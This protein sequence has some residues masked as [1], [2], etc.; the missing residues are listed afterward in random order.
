VTSEHGLSR[1]RVTAA[2]RVGEGWPVVPEAGVPEVGEAG[3]PV[4][5]VIGLVGAVVACA[6]RPAAALAVAARVGLPGAGPGVEQAPASSAARRAMHSLRM[7]TDMG[8]PVTA[9]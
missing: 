3:V 2:T 5:G 6:S 8:Q 9:A 1:V 7:Y 4:A